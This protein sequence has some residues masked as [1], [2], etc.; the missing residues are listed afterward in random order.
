M[1][2]TGGA[3]GTTDARS[4]ERGFTIVE[5]MIV[6]FIIAILSAIAAPAMNGMIRAQKVRSTAYDFFADL[7]FARSEAISRGRNVTIT[8]AS[9]KNWVNGW[10][11]NDPLEPKPLREEGARST[12][13][14]FEADQGGV[15]FDRTGRTLSGTI[16]FTIAPVD[17]D[18][19]DSQ[20]RCIRIDP[21]G[22]PRSTTGICT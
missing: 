12:G 7:T 16:S 1:V 4:R 3:M 18:A 15:T 6:V 11:I 9:G 5:A 20:K 8:S 14:V 13:L 17:L 2:T 10:T 22:R 19:P 21:S